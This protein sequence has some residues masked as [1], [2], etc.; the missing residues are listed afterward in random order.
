MSRKREEKGK[1]FPVLITFESSSGC[2]W[3]NCQ[4]DHHLVDVTA[5]PANHSFVSATAELPREH[6]GYLSQYPFKTGSV[7]ASEGDRSI[8]QV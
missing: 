1:G 3:F 4:A 7:L 5:W 6:Y 2:H 8:T